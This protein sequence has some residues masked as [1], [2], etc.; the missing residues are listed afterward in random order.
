VLYSTYQSAYICVHNVVVYILYG[1]NDSDA[2]GS[3][4]VP[5]VLDWAGGV[6]FLGALFDILV[7]IL[8]IVV[9]ISR[10]SRH[11]S[12]LTCV[13]IVYGRNDY[14]ASCSTKSRLTFVYIL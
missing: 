11:I 6:T 1:R 4:I 2:S 9:H 14:D 3:T 13:Y 12:R 5:K 8:Y 7:V 10:L